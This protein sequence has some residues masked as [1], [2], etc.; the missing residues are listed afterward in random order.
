MLKGYFVGGHGEGMMS[1]GGVSF[2]AKCI[3]LLYGFV[4]AKEES[5]QEISHARSI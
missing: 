2:W 4:L 3:A 1:L 5:S